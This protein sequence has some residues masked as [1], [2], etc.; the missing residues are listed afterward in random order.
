MG[1]LLRSTVCRSTDFMLSLFVSHIRPII[2]YCSCLWNVG[3]LGDVRRLE[4]LQRRWNREI[5]GIGNLEYVFRLKAIGLYSVQGRLLRSDLIKIWKS[6]NSEIDVGLSELFEMAANVG[7]RGHYLKMS[8]P[9]CRSEVL[10]RSFAVRRVMLWNS[11]PAD[12]VGVSS[13][14]SFK[15]GL[16][17]FL[18]ERLFEVS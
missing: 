14:G 12:L 9:I 10:R 17:V 6:F 5:D 13:L 2:D 16:D 15:G 8:I 4:S 11:L 3:Y 7:T 18:A 1:E